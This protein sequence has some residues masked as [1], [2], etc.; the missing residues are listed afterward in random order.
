MKNT[1]IFLLATCLIA[2]NHF[3]KAQS[4]APVNGD[5]SGILK[6]PGGNLDLIFKIKQ[7][8]QNITVKM[9]VPAQRAK[10]LPANKS[11]LKGDSISIGFSMMQAVY[12]GVFIKDS[13]YIR[14]TWEQAGNVLPLKLTR[15]EKKVPIMQ[16]P[17]E[18]QPP[19]SYNSEE[20]KFDNAKA[21][22]K[23][24]GTFTWPKDKNNCPV[25]ILITGSGPQDRNEELMGHKPFLVL[26]DQLSKNGI[27]VLRFDDRGVGESGGNF[28]SATTMDFATDVEAAYQYVLTRKEIDPKKI[29]LLGH[30]EG[31]L[32]APMVASRNPT[33]NFV[34]M[35]AGPG[36]KGSEV[37]ALQSVALSKAMDM[38]P[39]E[40]K[41]N[42]VLNRKIYALALKN[43]A[44]ADDSIQ[45]LLKTAGM[46]DAEAKAQSKAV[47][48][49]WFRGFIA[50][51][52]AVYLSKLTCNV[53][54]ING[55]KD[56]QVVYKENLEAIEKNL[57]HTKSHQTKAYDELN[58]LFQHAISGAPSEYVSIDETMSPEVLSDI[59]NWILQLK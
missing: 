9:D 27:A 22:I 36:V 37:I 48:S 59:T 20:V 8:K 57:T 26:A 5:W 16:R 25:V 11:S 35:L 53:F 47:L 38:D 41:K 44:G 55:K 51:D 50:S 28:S 12:K 39:I 33:I 42:D 4:V 17:Q 24:A 30:S 14:G 43:A 23:L 56:V 21:Q 31:G 1:Q 13:A 6:T 10:D 18:P 2:S 54:A 58:H 40:I 45:A 15:Y 3:T 49:P 32:I 46:A 29:G 7:D 19:F 52:P 34:V